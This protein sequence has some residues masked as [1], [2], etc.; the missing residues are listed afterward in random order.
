MRLGIWTV[1]GAVACALGAAA[2]FG[3]CV[4]RKPVPA[5]PSSAGGSGG[6]GACKVSPGQFPPPSCDDTDESC[7]PPATACPTTPCSGTSPCLAMTDNTAKPV[8]NLR[9]RKLNVTAPPALALGFIQAGVIDLGVNLKNFCGEPGD[10]SFSWLIQFDPNS[11]KLTTGGAPP[12]DDP[13]GVGYCFVK[14]TLSNI[15]VTPVTIQMTKGSDGTWSSDVIDKLNVPIYVH[16]LESNVVVLPLSKSK[17]TGVT[18][19]TDGN[20]IGS[21]NPNGVTP[22]SPLGTCQ[23]QDPSSCQRWH[24]AGSLGGYITL[25]EAEGVQVQ[26]LGKTLCVLLTQGSDTANGGKDCATD[27]Q[28]NVT[29]K[30]DFCS[31][32]NSPATSDCADSMWLAATIAASAA[33]INDGTGNADCDGSKLT[34]VVDAGPDSPPDAGG[35]GDA[36]AEA[37]ATDAATD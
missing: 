20:C 3:G 34:G 36:G 4:S 9:I 22:P 33:V 8:Q 21:Y 29:A 31:K 27:A 37:G 7:A 10:G 16:G 1:S 13:F 2:F 26:D 6:G 24:T 15:Q 19:S 12:V 28:G 35:G 32:T 18:I 30:G 23:D 25:N 14:A 11:G 17:V 5:P